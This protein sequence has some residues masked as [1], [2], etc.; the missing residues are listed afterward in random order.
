MRSRKVGLIGYMAWASVCGAIDWSLS[1][2]EAIVSLPVRLIAHLRMVGTDTQSGYSL[3]LGVTLRPIL[4]VMGLAISLLAV[5]GHAEELTQPLTLKALQ[6]IDRGAVDAQAPNGKLQPRPEGQREAAR[7]YGIRGG[8]SIRS[9]EIWQEIEPMASLLDR[10][11]DF[12]AL[13]LAAPSG[14]L[15]E[16]PVVE[17]AAAMEIGK[18][19]DR[20]EVIGRVYR[21]I[22]SEGLV[23]APRSWR[24]YLAGRHE[25]FAEVTLPSALLLPR[26]DEERDI[27]RKEVAKGYAIGVRQ[28]DEIYQGDVERLRRDFV[29]M[30]QFRLLVT[31]GVMNMPVTDEEDKGV[32]GGGDV[33]YVGNRVVRI[34]SNS[35][36]DKKGDAWQPTV[37]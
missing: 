37:R 11:F 27:W 12:R 34:L 18:K 23:T 1:I 33:L 32:T 5:A 25:D 6:E 15:I 28:A 4:V 29:G 13:M 21:K 17:E 20:A 35:S 22:M 16:P 14:L 9:R 8:L 36:L 30:V 2:I 19:R 10:V 3:L 31:E 26:T 24:D 7:S